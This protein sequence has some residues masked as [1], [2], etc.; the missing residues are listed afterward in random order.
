MDSFH[1]GRRFDLDQPPGCRSIICDASSFQDIHSDQD[2]VELKRSFKD[3][4][5]R[6]IAKQVL[7]PLQRFCAMTVIRLHQHA[8]QEPL[9]GQFTKLRSSIQQGLHGLVPLRGQFRL[10]DF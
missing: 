5:Y 2:L 1:L 3:R 10:V 6:R 9:A 8:S 4:R 7:R